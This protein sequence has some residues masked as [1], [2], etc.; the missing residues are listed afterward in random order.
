MLLFS[1]LVPLTITWAAAHQN[2]PHHVHHLQTQCLQH[3]T[4]T[5]S[6]PA[7]MEGRGSFLHCHF[8]LSAAY[9]SPPTSW[10]VPLQQEAVNA[11]GISIWYTWECVGILFHLF[12]YFTVKCTFV[13]VVANVPELSRNRTAHLQSSRRSLKCN[14]NHACLEKIAQRR[15]VEYKWWDRKR[16]MTISQAH[17]AWLTSLNTKTSINR[18]IN[19]K[20]NEIL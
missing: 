16:M 11:V 4:G 17:R 3:P 14:S 2:P 13:K 20:D 18:H 19:I 5:A 6:Q 10:H 9:I 7:H 1:G 12:L 8:L 15:H